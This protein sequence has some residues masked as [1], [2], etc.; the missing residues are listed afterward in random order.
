MSK[1]SRPSQS[2][3]DPNG[4]SLFK[5]KEMDPSD[6]PR[7][8]LMKNGANS[9]SESELRMNVLDLGRWVLM[10]AGGLRQ[11]TRKNWAELAMEPGIGSA[12]A[13]TLE[14]VFELGRRVQQTKLGDRPKIRSP[15]EAAAYF[16]PKIMDLNKEVFIV[17]FLN[18]SKILTGSRRISEGG[19]TATVVDPAEVYRQAIL[20]N[21]ASIIVAHNHPS[22]MVGESH[23]DRL[24]TRRL[25][26]VGRILGVP[27]DDHIIIAGDTYL[28]FRERNLMG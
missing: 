19:M 18:N 5:V 15:Q 13:V 9:L 11:L 7:E 27:L 24:L 17:A 16:R 21:A 8:K 23:A 1:E 14:A 4:Q 28:S 25:H 12:K 22:G 20:N 26:E 6:K 10:Q 3:P 2:G